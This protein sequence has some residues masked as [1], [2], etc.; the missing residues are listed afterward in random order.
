MYGYFQNLQLKIISKRIKSR[1]L[2]EIPI[3]KKEDIISVKK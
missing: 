2:Y 1:K 3:Y